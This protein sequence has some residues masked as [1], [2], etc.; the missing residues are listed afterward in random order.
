MDRSHAHHTDQH[1]PRGV[2][3]DVQTVG[4]LENTVN[5][6]LEILLEIDN[7]NIINTT[8]LFLETRVQ[9]VDS[10]CCGDLVDP[11]NPR[12]GEDTTVLDNNMETFTDFI[13]L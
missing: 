1:R 10:Y 13:Q 9:E 2:G 4:E 3:G 8:N 11:D 5:T 7:N 6:D 12:S